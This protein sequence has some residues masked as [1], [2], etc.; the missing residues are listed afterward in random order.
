MTARREKPSRPSTELALALLKARFI[1]QKASKLSLTPSMA[2]F[3]DEG[4]ADATA[5]LERHVPKLLAEFE[6]AQAARSV[7]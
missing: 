4:A 5:A 3:L 7:R 2:K 6:Q 1:L